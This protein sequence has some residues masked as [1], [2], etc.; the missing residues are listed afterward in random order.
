MYN[1]V[2]RNRTSG[3]TFVDIVDRSL[4][5]EKVLEVNEDGKVPHRQKF[6]KSS[7]VIK[8]EFDFTQKEWNIYYYGMVDVAAFLG[9]L[10]GFVSLILVVLTPV[11]IL[12]F[13][14]ELATIMTEKYN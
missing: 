5:F 9:G 14:I 10:N 8:F 4:L 12:M 1:H 7:A 6:N 13:L 2:K 11:F 3:L